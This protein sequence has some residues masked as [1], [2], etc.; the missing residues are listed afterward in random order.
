MISLCDSYSEEASWGLSPLSSLFLEFS[1]I[2]DCIVT[3]KPTGNI[4]SRRPRP[5]WEENI[6][7]DLKE[8]GANMRN[9]VDSAQNGDYWRA[10]VNVAFNL[11]VP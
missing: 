1:F 8:I 5:R 6:R 4:S 10:I 7:M 11:H 3:G 2:F 9:W